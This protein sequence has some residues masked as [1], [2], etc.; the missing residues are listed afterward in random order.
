MV[1]RNLNVA[2]SA[3]LGLLL[4]LTVAAGAAAAPLE[5]YGRLPTLESVG[6]SPDGTRLAFVRTQGDDRLLIVVALATGK[7][8]AGG[9][10]GKVKLRDVQWAD[11]RRLLLITSVTEDLMEFSGGKHEWT[12]LQVFD[13]EKRTLT[14]WPKLNSGVNPSEP[15]IM[16]VIESDPTIRRIGGHTVLFVT[17]IYVTDRTLPLLFRID[18][19]E[20]SQRIVRQGSDST[21]EWIV[22]DAGAV[23]AEETYHETDHHWTLRYRKGSSLADAA[24]GHE[25]ID[26]PHLLGFGPVDDTLLVG[27][28]ENGDSVWR[29]FSLKDGTLGAPMAEHASLDSPI[30]DMQTHRMIG[31]IDVQDDSRY[32]FFDATRQKWWD[33]I[34]RGFSDEHVEL[35]SASQDFKKVVVRVNGPSF[36]YSYQLVDMDTHKASLVGDVYDGIVRPM[37]VQR[38]D[39]PAADGLKLSAY[40]TLPAGKEPKRLPLIVLPHGGPAVRDTADFDWWS[41]ALAAQG[42][43]VL[44]PN[45]RGSTVNHGLLEA[46]YGQWGRKMQTDLSDAVRY[47]AKAE[48]IDPARVCIVGASYGGY[49]ALAGVTL[50]PGVYRCSV[51]VAGIGD[52]QRMLSW[53]AR[54]ASKRTVRYWDRFMGVTGA[55]DARLAEISPIRH[56][57]AVTV[58]VML[59]HGRDD[60]VV[61]FEQSQQMY[62]A[63][64]QAHK[65]VE[66]VELKHEDHWLSSSETRLQMLQASVAFLRQHNPPD[67]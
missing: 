49:A 4:V 2:A 27:L 32:V 7:P 61:P 43:A 13:I 36:G 64:K 23:V 54:D 47:L 31:G 30:E 24:V 22:D 3:L 46:G 56:L 21:R 11:D 60:T 53:E 12:G 16:N 18:L 10:I 62:D 28:T 20:G 66:L 44:R 58:P 17:G 67:P 25:S 40:L 34:V 35:V 37:A 48:T 5:V 19:D 8:I 59:I 29:L 6:I 63:L 52:L 15:N 51:A 39:Y 38:I 50:D 9:H 1:R 26:I 55:S 14:A 42:Y 57:D 45:Y 33:A 65:S 41:Q